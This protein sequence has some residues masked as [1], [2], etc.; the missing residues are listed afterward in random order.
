MT[1][2]QKKTFLDYR[3]GGK[4]VQ[5]L[6][7]FTSGFLIV[8]SVVLKEYFKSRTNTGGDYSYLTNQLTKMTI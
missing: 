3:L 2:C 5:A 1:L 7:F 4:A 8:V 6:F